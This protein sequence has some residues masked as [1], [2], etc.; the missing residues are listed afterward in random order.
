MENNEEPILPQTQVRDMCDRITCEHTAVIT[1]VTNVRTGRDDNG[2]RYRDSFTSAV[3]HI[4]EVISQSFPRA[5]ARGFN[6]RSRVA[7]VGGRNPSGR[8][9]GC[10]RF[11][12]R[13]RGGRWSRGGGRNEGGRFT[14]N[15]YGPGRANAG[16]KMNNGVDISDLT[17]WYSAE[18]LSKVAYEVRQ[19]I[20]RAKHE[21]DNKRG[22]SALH[23]SDPRDTPADTATPKLPE[24]GGQNGKNFGS[25]GYSSSNSTITTRN[26]NG[27]RPA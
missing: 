24:T 18:E 17:R 5:Q 16:A 22:V 23:Q 14:P 7:S 25:G 21:R 1:A 26:Q 4:S 6:K 12:G 19:D 20:W 9:R 13:G 10:G 2:I 3:N 15:F 27:K 8:G 11:P